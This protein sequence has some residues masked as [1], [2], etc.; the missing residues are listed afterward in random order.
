[1]PYYKAFFKGENNTLKS[2]WK[3]FVF[4][5][6]KEYYHKGKLEICKSGFHCCRHPKDCYQYY[7]PKKGKIV[8]IH[9]VDVF[10]DILWYNSN[11]LC[12]NGLKIG[13]KLSDEEIENA[14]TEHKEYHFGQTFNFID[15]KPI[16]K[17][18]II[19]PDN[20]IIWYKDGAIHRDDCDPMSELILPSIVRVNEENNVKYWHKMG[21][22]HRDDRDP[23]S[24]L[25]LPACIDK[26][27]I[28]RWSK[29][30]FLHQDDIDLVTG[31]L[32]PAIYYEGHKYFYQNGYQ[33][34]KE[35]M[36][37]KDYEIVQKYIDDEFGK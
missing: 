2:K 16:G 37:K 35:K 23:V 1:M 3:K 13:R 31:E 29:N 11:K 32:L 18:Y 20:G 27:G 26:R 9:E 14:Y 4:E 8:V 36:L 12:T 21:K 25:V 30:G 19:Y 33:I 5:E 17:Y 15:G 28:L 10:G 34:G 6:G 22:R 7:P 24:G